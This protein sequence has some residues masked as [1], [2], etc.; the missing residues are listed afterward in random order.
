MK[1]R[2]LFFVAFLTFYMSA[3][4]QFSN[5]TTEWYPGIVILNDEEIVKGNISYDYS[6][7]IVMCK[8][9]EI[10]QTFTPHQVHSFKY[11]DEEANI[12][13]EYI[14]LSNEINPRYQQKAFYEVL[15]EGDINYVRKRNRFPAYNAKEGYL[16]NR[17]N[18]LNEHK[19]CYEYF[20]Q[21]E[22]ELIKS[23]RFKQEVLP[24]MKSK[25]QSLQA[26]MKK[27]QLKPYDI[28]DQIELVEYYNN[29][30]NLSKPTAS[31]SWEMHTQYI[32]VV[33]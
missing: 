2:L 19:V 30:S 13:H 32:M 25:E 11:F 28:G 14:T 27:N 20:V 15:L 23:R 5:K 18:R 9:G 7:D 10:I 16:A 21:Y 29:A 26:F 6:H 31:Q 22:D 3:Y 12:F 1:M 17:N 24:I 8:E 33:D 4:A